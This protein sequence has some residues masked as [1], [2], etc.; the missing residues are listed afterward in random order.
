MP[1]PF[2]FISSP[3]FFPFLP[4]TSPSLDFSFPC[5][6]YLSFPFLPFPSLAFHLPFL[7][8]PYLS[9]PFPTLPCPSPLPH[10]K[11]AVRL[12]TACGV[13]INTAKLCFS[14][15]QKIITAVGWTAFSPRL[16]RKWSCTAFSAG[17]NFGFERCEIFISC[18]FSA[19]GVFF[20]PCDGILKIYIS[21]AAMPFPCNWILC[22]TEFSVAIYA[23]NFFREHCCCC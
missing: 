9:L 7:T 3:R 5:F 15:V 20:Q 16:R 13:P 21:S 22:T 4:L 10:L 14:T 8:L 17:R 19:G 2:T 12:H 23:T 18:I 6:S 1:S 11:Q